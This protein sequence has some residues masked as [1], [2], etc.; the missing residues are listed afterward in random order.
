MGQICD[1]GKI[2]AF[3]DKKAE[4]WN[5]QLFTENQIDLIVEISRET[6]TIRFF[7]KKENKENKYNS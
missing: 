5:K 2:D 6:S 3:P 1:S 4:I 7:I